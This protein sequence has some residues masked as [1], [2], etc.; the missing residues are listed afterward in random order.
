MLPVSAGSQLVELPLETF[1]MQPSED[2]RE[3]VSRRK[4]EDTKSRVC[5]QHTSYPI[6]LSHIIAS[7]L[8]AFRALLSPREANQLS[9]RK[10]RAARALFVQRVE[11]R[12]ELDGEGTSQLGN[13]GAPAETPRRCFH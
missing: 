8:R 6:G 2:C 3:H 11:L 9:G 10:G 12:V 5:I 1:K 7:L 13:S 4:R